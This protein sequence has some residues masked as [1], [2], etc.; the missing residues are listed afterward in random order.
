M[1]NEHARMCDDEQQEQHPLRNTCAAIPPGCEEDLRED[2]PLNQRLISAYVRLF[3]RSA[4]AFVTFSVPLC[5]FG[6][7]QAPFLDYFNIN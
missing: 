4:R 5:V 3:A 7:F 1:C 6:R 2:N